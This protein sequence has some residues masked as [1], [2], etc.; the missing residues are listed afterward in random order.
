MVGIWCFLFLFIEAEFHDILLLY[1]KIDI[2][3]F[4]S[5][6]SCV[7]LKSKFKMIFLNLP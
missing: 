6:F 7:T 3:H 1:F 2:D 5:T 4:A